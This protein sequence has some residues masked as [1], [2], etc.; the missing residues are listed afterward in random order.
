[1]TIACPYCG[2]RY[3]LPDHLLGPGGARVRCPNCQ[4]SFVV[5]AES[6]PPAPPAD[7]SAPATTL[8]ARAIESETPRS[9]SPARGPGD[10]PTE[11]GAPVPA[12]ARGA[13]RPTPVRPPRAAPAPPEDEGEP[14]PAATHAAIA[15]AVLDALAE[16]HGGAIEA[17]NASGRLFSEFGPALFDAY[18]DYRRRVGRRAGA[19]A[20]RQ[21]LRERW[22][23][24]L[25]VVGEDEERR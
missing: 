8:P 9:P 18:D 25:P 13:K 4:R 1:M 21:A 24:D 5:P 15:R 23:V 3:L 10:V 2:T 12:P 20:F 16:H 17:A 11:G 22:N 14:A 19:A 7:A 6:G